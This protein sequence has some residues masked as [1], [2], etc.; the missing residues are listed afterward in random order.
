[1]N[2]SGT[3]QKIVIHT[4]NKVKHVPFIFVPN[5][6]YIILYIHTLISK[7]ADYPRTYSQL[8]LSHLFASSATRHQTDNMHG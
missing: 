4:D 1:M 5:C 3:V 6:V 8:T 7:A 2:F